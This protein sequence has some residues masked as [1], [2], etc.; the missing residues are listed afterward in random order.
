MARKKRPS[1]RASRGTVPTSTRGS[2]RRAARLVDHRHAQPAKSAARIRNLR[3]F[4][5]DP[6][7][8]QSL[9][10]WRTNEAVISLP[11]E[12]LEPGPVGEYLEV[13]DVDPASGLAYA[14]I[15]L[16]DADVARRNGYAPSEID[17]RF[18]QQMVY[19]V[20]M[21]T[22]VHFEQSL[23]RDA[24]WKPRWVVRGGKW[25][26]VFVQ[27]LRIYPHALRE[28]NAYYSPD[29]VSLLFGYFQTPID[30]YTTHFPGGTVFTCLSHD[31][32][33]HETTHALLDGLHPKFSDES[34]QDVAAFHEAF[35]DIVALFSR[36]SMREV[37]IQEI[38]R[39]RGSLD[40]EN[41]L[42]ALAVQMGT[43][44]GQR[45]ALRDAIGRINPT[46]GRWER[47]DPDPRELAE[48]TE[49][50]ARGAILVAAVFDAFLSIYRSRVADLLRIATGGTGVLPQ[51]DLHPDLVGRLTDEAVKS[52]RHILHMCIRALDYCPPVDITFGEYLRA[53]VTADYD[54]M[55][56][57]ER[58]YRVAVVESFSRYGIYPE[59]SRSLLA[60]AIRWEEPVFG[61][62]FSKLLGGVNFR[63]LVHGTL[64]Q[65][66][67]ERIRA[68]SKLCA[69]IHGRLSSSMWAEQVLWQ[70]GLQIGPKAPGS[71][72]VG[73]GNG[74]PSFQV[75]GLR[76]ARR[77]GHRGSE[78]VDIVLEI[79][80]TRDGYLDPDVQRKA[81][82]RRPGPTRPK[83]LP[84]PDFT[85][86]GGCTLFINPDER[87][88]RFC[89][90]KNIMSDPR[91]ERTRQHWLKAGPMGAAFY[92]ARSG[93]P[94]AAL[95]CH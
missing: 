13:I 43:A 5:Y 92:G 83:D 71:V 36:F 57:D 7:Q 24:F 80:Q 81:D 6:S 4:A 14:P 30:D 95:H 59:A 29:K 76:P 1:R 35:S 91:L 60:D 11:D 74:Q 34:N 49:P 51:G 37:V 50:H 22:I 67:A 16:T 89:I 31:V 65:S 79:T 56:E 2:P 54:M 90:A 32:I 86:R 58:N 28:A 38:R 46:T 23:G 15:N 9:A 48:T 87:N 41:Q 70:A 62:L 68:T 42:G 84:P 12:K 26:P 73:S 94:F 78:T 77:L 44:L 10:M 8:S 27:R 72:R 33:A 20:A 40:A 39:A 63:D 52:A 3:V 75:D 85:F 61:D 82:Q 45:G 55:P 19:A 53:L 88:I 66:R 64:G 69:E 18:H 17:Y 21:N 93:E 47:R 25:K